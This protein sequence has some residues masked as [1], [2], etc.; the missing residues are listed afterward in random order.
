MLSAP[1][2]NLADRAAA[3]FVAHSTGTIIC[4]L[5]ITVL[6]VFPIFLLSPTEQASQ[7]PGGPVFDLRDKVNAQFPAQFHIASFI[8]EDREGDVLRQATLWELYRNQE[9]L[10]QSDMADNLFYGYNADTG[11][12]IQG[13]YT[14]AD[15]VNDVLRL[16]PASSVTLET[17]T[18]AQVK[19][20]IGRVLEGPTG[21][22]LRES[23]S[24]DASQET[25]DVDGQERQEWRA[26]A[27]TIF[28]TADNARLGG[29]PQTISLS[30]DSLV[31]EKERLN[32]RLLTTLRGNEEHYRMWGLALDVNLTSREQGATAVPYIAATVVLVLAVVGIT[33]R[34][35]KAVGLGFIGMLILLV[36]L[37]GIS[38][39]IGLNSSL[40]LDLI[41]PIAMISLGADFLIHA[42]DRYNEEKAQHARP[43]KALRFGLA[44]VLGALVLASL[45]DGIAFLA[46]I[47][48]GIE[49]IIGFGIAAGI[50]VLSNFVIMGILIPLVIMRL[51]ERRTPPDE[52]L[53]QNT[54]VWEESGIESSRPRIAIAGVVSAL[55]RAPWLVIP[56]VALGTALTTY[57][58]FQLEPGFDPKDFFDA[59]SEFVVGLDKLDEYIAPSLSGEP[60]IIYVRG[61]F[62]DPKALAGL[63]ELLDRLSSNRNVGQD[64]DGQVFLYSRTIFQLLGRVTST[65]AARRAVENSTG[66][67]ITDAD[68]DGIPDTS[69]QLKASYEYM[70]DNGVPLDETTLAYNTAQV[71]QIFAR[72]GDE[73]ATAISL[74][75]LGAGEQANL[76][77]AR[78]SLGRDLAPLLELEPISEVGITGS[79]F[80]REATL[81]AT[82]RALTISL[83]VAALA[84]FLLLAFWMRSVS[85]AFVTI[86]PVGLVV[87]WLYA[88]MYLAGYTLNF[89]TA[90]IAA[91][92]IGVG[93]DFSIHMTQRYRQ[94]LSRNFDPF[95]SLRIAGAG[96]GMALTGSA[97]SSVIGFAVMGFAPMPLFATYG[98]ISAVMVLMAGVAS[99]LVLPSMLLVV[100]RLQQRYQKAA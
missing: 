98:I 11:Q 40:T 45:S 43:R 13:I 57:L 55:A 24:K 93:I 17:A 35:F 71:R 94:E 29:G 100:T 61:D 68:V 62:T 18:D 59:D 87:S 44:G 95:N 82:T 49:T 89:V 21:D 54:T 86:I 31:L 41:V 66:I 26:R 97:A 70:V 19:A 74:G 37:K 65:E 84:C 99:L 6:L 48:S 8:V 85:F 75:I 52:D 83:P 96:T 1:R 77:A 63:E 25:R 50:A 30:N 67:A 38:N 64:Q 88:F 36:W 73:Y 5:A 53:A 78:K 16:D 4:I 27:L 7:E 47:T 51:E 60:A 69:E 20:A 3:F 15:A 81:V 34:S 10:R 14:V 46:N 76:A 91:V 22:F 79:P 39:L 80:T 58:A 23:F 28:V 9:A 33:L 92:S 32:R 56:L 42:V 72:E 12:S 2:T 90:T